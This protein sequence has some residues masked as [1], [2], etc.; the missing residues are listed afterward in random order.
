[1]GRL[2]VFVLAALCLGAWGENNPMVGTWRASNGYRVVIPAG[3]PTFQL[4][5][6][7]PK[8]TRISHPARWVKRGSEFS[9]VDKNGASH[10]ATLDPTYKPQRIRDIGSAFPDSPGYW[11]K[12]P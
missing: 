11:Y 4:I 7:D 2:I 1:M 5:F 3:G 6:R 10:T 9:W 12:V 8:G